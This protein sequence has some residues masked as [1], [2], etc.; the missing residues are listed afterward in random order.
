[1]LKAIRKPRWGEQIVFAWVR[2]KRELLLGQFCL[3]REGDAMAFWT[4]YL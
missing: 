4:G 1:V 2:G 3:S